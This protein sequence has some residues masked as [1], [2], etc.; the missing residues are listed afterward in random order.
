MTEA[1]IVFQLC[2]YWHAGSGAGSGASLDAVVIRSGN[3]L[4]FLPGRTV[5][6]LLREAVTL[7]EECRRVDAGTAEKLFG[8]RGPGKERDRFGTTPGILQ[9]SS[10]TLGD[11]MEAWAASQPG[12]SLKQNLYR[13][14]S[15]TAIN[16]DGLADDQSL[17]RIELVVPTTLKARVSPLETTGVDW[18]QAL[19]TAAPLVRRLGS[20]RHRGFGRVS[21]SIRE[22]TP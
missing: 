11:G 19:R 1:E 10:A 13:E 14:L 2:G 16:E 8:N 5:K 18:I 9:F 20:H 6:G 4:P 12:T 15:M 3:G 7:A 22:V 21:V 17:R